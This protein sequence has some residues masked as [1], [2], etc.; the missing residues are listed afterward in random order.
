M[1][2]MTDSFGIAEAAGVPP[3]Q[4]SV[5]RYHS[6]GD[7]SQPAAGVCVRPAVKRD[8]ADA[9]V[10]RLGIGDEANDVLP[11]QGALQQIPIVLGVEVGSR[12][13]RQLRTLHVHPVHLLVDEDSERPHER[14]IVLSEALLGVDYIDPTGDRPAHLR[15]ESRN[16]TVADPVAVRGGLVDCDATVVEGQVDALADEQLLQVPH[17]MGCCS[18]DELDA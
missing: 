18:R 8:R 11:S 7:G 14:V 5:G 4:S 15:R 1:E 16:L 2:A 10:V 17:A 9:V 6:L 3:P 12:D 13:E